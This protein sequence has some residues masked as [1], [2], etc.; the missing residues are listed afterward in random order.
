MSAQAAEGTD[1]RRGPR[2]RV[3]ALCCVCGRLRTVSVNYCGRREEI[4]E[5]GWARLNWVK[6][7]TCGEVTRHAVLT[8][9]DGRDWAEEAQR[10]VVL[11]HELLVIALS[12]MATV[13]F[14]PFDDVECALFVEQTYS[15]KAWTV[16]LNE[17]WPLD[18][19]IQ[20][21]EAALELLQDG[22]Y[23]G[24]QF[25]WDSDAVSRSADLFALNKCRDQIREREQLGLLRTSLGV[26]TDGIAS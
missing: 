13:E 17:A 23:G 19:Q 8:D 10:K 25:D 11:K 21:L 16:L 9:G 15:D 5:P 20:V 4:L 18:L 26:G 6:C 12:A 3:R 24:R 1:R 14:V 22:K 2:K 7:A